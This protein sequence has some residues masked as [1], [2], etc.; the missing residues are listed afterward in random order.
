MCPLRVS[1]LR[2]CAHNDRG[3]DVSARQGTWFARVGGIVDGFL[4]QGALEEVMPKRITTGLKT[5]RPDQP[6][7]TEHNLRLH[8]PFL[9]ILGNIGFII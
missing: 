2:N 1:E 6:L 4:G 7:N 3:L 8:R 9:S 5:C